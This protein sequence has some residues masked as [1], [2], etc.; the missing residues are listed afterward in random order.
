MCFLWILDTV[1]S[2]PFFVTQHVSDGYLTMVKVD[3][4]FE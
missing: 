4:E 1:T 3:E 2:I